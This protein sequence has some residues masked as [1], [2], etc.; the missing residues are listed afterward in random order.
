VVRNDPTDT[1]KSTS[2]SMPESRLI[3][4]AWRIFAMD[5]ALGAVFVIAALTD[6][7]DPAGRGLAE[8]YAV[9]CVVVLAGFGAIL[10]VSTYLRSRIGLWLSIV[11]MVTPPMLYVY[12]V[13]TRVMSGA[14]P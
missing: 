13:A 9:G 7:G 2:T 14:L 8:I 5:V 12:G 10:G 4:V 1:A 11:L 6:T 3:K